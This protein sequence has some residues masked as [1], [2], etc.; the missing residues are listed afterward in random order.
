MPP[1]HMK[2]ARKYMAIYDSQ[3]TQVFV[4][5]AI[6]TYGCL[7]LAFDEFLVTLRAGG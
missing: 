2:V 4:L 5:L 3:M 1:V 7:D 6:E